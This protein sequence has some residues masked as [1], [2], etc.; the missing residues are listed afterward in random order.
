MCESYGYEIIDLGKDIPVDSVVDAYKE[1]KPKAIGLSALMTTTVENMKRTIAALRANDCDV[2]I[3]VG[4]A[5]LTEEIAKEIDADYYT[6][7]AMSLVNLFKELG[8]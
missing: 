3:M 1:Y 7:D 2:P 8:V 4:G 6:E 5:V